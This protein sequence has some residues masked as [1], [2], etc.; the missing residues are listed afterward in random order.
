MFRELWSLL[1]L[2]KFIYI[3]LYFHI[4]IRISICLSTSMCLHRLHRSF[5]NLIGGRGT[6]RSEGCGQDVH[7][8]TYTHML[9]Q[10]FSKVETRVLGPWLRNLLCFRVHPAGTLSAPISMSVY[11]VYIPFHLIHANIH[12][13]E[14]ARALCAA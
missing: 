14:C 4:Y 1:G 9:E 2:F 8:P 10:K 3:H 13:T 11:N 6:D 7:E 12:F 5:R